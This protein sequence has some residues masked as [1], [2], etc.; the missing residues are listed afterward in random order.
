MILNKVTMQIGKY[1]NK[2]NVSEFIPLYADARD[3][4]P[5]A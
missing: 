5:A 4:L 1:I 2:W 3:L